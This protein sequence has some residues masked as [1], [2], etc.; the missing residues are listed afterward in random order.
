MDLRC[1]RREQRTTPW[2]EK[3]C[4]VEEEEKDKEVATAVHIVPELVELEVAAA[5]HTVG[6]GGTVRVRTVWC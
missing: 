3:G 6:V 2:D 4:L 1:R 5:A